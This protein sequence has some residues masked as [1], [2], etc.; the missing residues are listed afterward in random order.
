MSLTRQKGVGPRIQVDKMALDQNKRE[1]IVY[2]LMLESS[3]CDGED[4][5]LIVSNF[6]EKNSE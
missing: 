1:G 5:F 2:R 6:S 4:S 3:D